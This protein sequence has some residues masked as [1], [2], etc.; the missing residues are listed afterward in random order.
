MLHAD[1]PHLGMGRRR[2]PTLQC[3]SH[4]DFNL[5]SLLERSGAGCR[6]MH[7]LRRSGDA[8]QAAVCRT[9]I[10]ERWW[11]LEGGQWIV[12]EL[13]P[14]YLGNSSLSCRFLERTFYTNALKPRQNQPAYVVNSSRF[15]SIP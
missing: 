13:L 15:P 5:T 11:T 1:V 2:I 7:L 8:I 4:S 9:Q 3:S 10:K 14:T 6:A 12:P